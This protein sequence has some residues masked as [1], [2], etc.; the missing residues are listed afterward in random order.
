[1]GLAMKKFKHLD[2]RRLLETLLL[3]ANSR[4]GWFANWLGIE[5]H[6]LLRPRGALEKVITGK[7]D[8][9]ANPMNISDLKYICYV[10]CILK[11]ILIQLQEI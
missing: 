9:I 3:L 11:I 5:S 8:Y 1:M 7:S 2:G 4:T 10:F 6:A